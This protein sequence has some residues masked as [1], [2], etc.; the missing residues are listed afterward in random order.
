MSGT[1]FLQTLAERLAEREPKHSNC[2]KRAA[3]ALI[4]RVS[5]ETPS[6]LSEVE[7]LYILRTA[8]Q[9]DKWSGHVAFPGGK[10]EASDK[11]DR[12]AAVRETEEEIGLHLESPDFEFLGQLDDRVVTGA[13]KVIDGFYLA[14]LLWFQRATTTPPI[15]MQS[16]EVAAWRWVPLS[17]LNPS[18][19]KYEVPL[20]ITRELASK[21][22][23]FPSTVLPARLREVHIACIDLEAKDSESTSHQEQRF[24][25]WGLTFRATSDALVLGGAEELG[26]PPMK[27]RSAGANFLLAAWC[28]VQELRKK[29]RSKRHLLALLT[30]LSILAAILRLLRFA[31]LSMAHPSAA[32][33]AV[34]TVPP[35]LPAMHAMRAAMRAAGPGQRRVQPVML[36]GKSWRFGERIAMLGYTIGE[37]EA[38]F[39][40]A[41]AACYEAKEEAD[42][43]PELSGGA[44]SSEF[45][46]LCRKV[47]EAIAAAEEQLET[48]KKEAEGLK[49]G[50][51]SGI[52][53]DH[54]RAFMKPK[55]QLTSAKFV[56]AHWEKQVAV[57]RAAEV[58][59]FGKKAC[60][61]LRLASPKAQGS[62]TELLEGLG[63][64]RSVFAVT[65]STS[66]V[67]Q[68]AAAGVPSRQPP[69]LRGAKVSTTAP[70]EEQSSGLQLGLSKTLKTSWF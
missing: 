21:V 55:Q 37:M 63:V 60:A 51:A 62:G 58:Q 56:L 29:R 36:C 27:F 17:T 28:G 54:R 15:Q 61:A 19:V 1:S 39:D 35:A 49:R 24:R 8:R 66:E 33:P 38:L 68:D 69:A 44:T 31:F 18:T 46:E 30:C 11:D 64:G 52:L 22:F 16:S 47:A 23:G 65:T 53:D 57:T 6:D 2:T 45:A 41:E 67:P 40:K 42:R 12:A 20:Q 7:L 32:V 34:P 25:L 9:G 14:P 13:G 50:D 10:R 5:S 43:L 48:A 70:S 3:V 26:W 4:F 59:D